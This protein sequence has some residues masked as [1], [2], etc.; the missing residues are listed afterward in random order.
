MPTGK[1]S[2]QTGAGPVTFMAK[3]KKPYRGTPEQLERKLI[4]KGTHP[5]FAAQAAQK[6]R[7]KRE[8]DALEKPR[9]TTRKGKGKK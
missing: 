5:A 2:F 8:R 3:Q 4:A 6:V 1:V 7:E 9:K